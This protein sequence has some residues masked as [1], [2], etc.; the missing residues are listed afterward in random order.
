MNTLLLFVSISPMLSFAQ[1]IVGDNIICDEGFKGEFRE[2]L[3]CMEKLEYKELYNKLSDDYLK[4]YF[5]NT[6][7]SAA[8]ERELKETSEVKV[9]KFVKVVSFRVI[10]EG[11]YEV[12][13]ILSTMS[14][15]EVLTV[16]TVYYFVKQING[17][18]FN[19]FDTEKY[20]VVE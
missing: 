20:E 17:W 3:H 14:E 12:E 6:T 10:A 5:P 2:I 13:L 4:K 8:Y 18:K 11:E 7:N 9:I 16:K 15:G 19:G 1:T